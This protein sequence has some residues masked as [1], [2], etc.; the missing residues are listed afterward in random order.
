MSATNANN[1]VKSRLWW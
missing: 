1:S